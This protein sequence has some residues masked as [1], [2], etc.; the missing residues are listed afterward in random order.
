MDD[1]K[2]IIHHSNVHSALSKED[3]NLKVDLLNDNSFVANPIL[4]S[5]HDSPDHLDHG[6]GSDMPVIDPEDLVGCT[7]LM[8]KQEDRT[9]FVLILYMLSRT[10]AMTWQ[11]ILIVSSFSVL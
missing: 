4:K 8:D 6:E 7:F 2:K 3:R 1:T 9:Q 11:I 5:R 10:M